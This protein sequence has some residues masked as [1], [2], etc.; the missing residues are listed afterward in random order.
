MLRAQRIDRP[1][2][3]VLASSAL[4]AL[5]APAITL[6]PGFG[7]ALVATVGAPTALA[8]TPDGRLLITTQGGALLATPALSLG[9][10]VCSNSEC[11]LLGVAADPAF[12]SNHYVYLYYTF[13]KNNEGCPTGTAA[14][15]THRATG[16]S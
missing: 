12:V 14:R 15:T 2:L 4:I 11:G 9:S 1:I 10:K 7:D 5:P 6:S 8:L 16:T 3:L 13:N